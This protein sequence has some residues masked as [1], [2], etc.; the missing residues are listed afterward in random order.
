MKLHTIFIC[1]L[2]TILV[3]PST[4]YPANAQTLSITSSQAEA[5]NWIAYVD[6]DDTLYV[7]HPDGSNKTEIGRD[8]AG[9][10]GLRWSSSGRYLSFISGTPLFSVISYPYTLWVW[11][12]QA[13][14]SVI[15]QETYIFYAWSPTNDVLAF[16]SLER[17]ADSSSF[18]S[19]NTY[20]LHLL[21][22][23]TGEKQMIL[24]AMKGSFAWLPD[25]KRIAFEPYWEAK[26]SS[27]TYVFNGW[28]EYSG[29]HTID[30]QTGEISTLIDPR[31]KPLTDIDISPQGS[32]VSFDE[33]RKFDG[34]GCAFH[35]MIASIPDTGEWRQLPYSFCV[36]SP[37]EEKLAC[38]SGGCGIPGEPVSI[39]DNNYQLL[40]EISQV[41]S[42]LSDAPPG[43]TLLWTPDSK[44]LAMGIGYWV[45]PPKRKATLIVDT[46][47]W[48]TLVDLQG[49]A[50]GWS[51]DGNSLL[52]LNQAE[53][54]SGLLGIYDIDSQQLQSLDVNSVKAAAWQPRSLL[55]DAPAN[56]SI[57]PDAGEQTYIIEW[58][59][60]NNPDVTYEVRYAF[61][62]INDANWE[63]AIEL[64]G[65]AR[66]EDDRIS[67][68]V[69]IESP[70]NGQSA[71]RIYTGV[72]AISENGASSPVAS[73]PWI[74]DWGFRA[75]VNG[76]QFGNSDPNIWRNE[77]V[78][79]INDFTEADMIA[80]FGEEAVCMQDNVPECILTNEAD[81]AYIAWIYWLGKGHCY[82]MAATSSKFFSGD[83]GI[84]EG[85]ISPDRLFDLTIEQSRRTIAYYHVQQFTNPAT[86][87]L[88]VDRN[89][90]LQDKVNKLIALLEN[91]EGAVIALYYPGIDRKGG[92]AVT[93]FSVSQDVD[94]QYRIWAYDSNYPS[95]RDISSI[96]SIQVN[97]Q[98]QSWEYLLNEAKRVT[99]RGQGAEDFF[100]VPLSLHSP[101]P[102]FIGANDPP[103]YVVQ[104]PVAEGTLHLNITNEDGQMVGFD[105]D[106]LVNQIEGAR[107]QP[108][109]SSLDA[110]DEPIYWLPA[111]RSYTVNILPV[112]FDPARDSLLSWIGG[113]FTILLNRDTLALPEQLAVNGDGKE[114]FYS[115]GQDGPASLMFSQAENDSETRLELL[116]YPFQAGKQLQITYDASEREYLVQ[117]SGETEITGDLTLTLHDGQG[118]QVI[119]KE[120]FQLLPGSTIHVR[121]KDWS[122]QG[123]VRLGAD[124]DND[125]QVEQ[126]K[127]E[128]SQVGLL[129]INWWLVLIG[130]ILMLIGGFAVVTG[131]FLFIR[132]RNI[133]REIP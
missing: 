44:L 51:P 72:R 78:G 80:M 120:S 38:N 56:V 107:I 16:T 37:N 93:P 130:G 53:S 39:Y 15:T 70:N 77:T 46:E 40:K 60:L 4:I 23:T 9:N 17:E 75:D 83:A 82:G 42:H 101:H 11:D 32:F 108:V 88:I 41:S 31:E 123:V 35:P 126:W 65:D 94:G 103:E 71:A 98:E 52:F 105:Q 21:D 114:I 1:T 106:T 86:D 7:I 97:L 43:G 34:P 30:I 89:L 96:R 129:A 116:R 131:I 84:F 50:F 29:I 90:S 27:G 28:V 66:I 19:K 95:F 33:V 117:Y 100:V 73:S 119:E 102:E 127:T 3:F 76:Y 113:S 104:A 48:D 18:P 61:Q 36:W 49:V 54:D 81:A 132:Q 92:H 2:I 45:T 121:V 74:V 87:A 112:S 14:Q 62:E 111:G 13:K 91:G 99:I 109:F 8:I 59:A 58:D 122:E 69:K 20:S 64:H 25:G 118:E 79:P 67:F 63:N 10:T 128:R 124:Q 47:S 85:G 57:R 6:K 24:P 110:W 12:Q 22:V 55:P 115:P 26:P 5:G 133:Q 68:P 125:G